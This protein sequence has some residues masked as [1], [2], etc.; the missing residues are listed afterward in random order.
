MITI[1]KPQISEAEKRAV[2]RVMDSGMIAYGAKV[3]EF[4]QSFADYCG[5]NHGVATTS[6]TTA[7]EVAL[8]ALGIAAGDKV[9]TTAWSFIASTNSILYTGAIPVFVDIDRVSFNIDPEGLESALKAHP[10][11]KAVQIVHLFGQPCNMDRIMPIIRKYGVWLIEDCAQAHGAEWNGQKV[12]SFGD[13]AAFSFY[14]TKNMTTGEGGIVLTKDPET[15]HRARLLTNHGMEQRYT[16]DILGYN[17]RMTNIS[18]AIGLEQLQ[19]LD[20]FNEARRKNADYYSQ[21]ISQP[22]VKTPHVPEDAHHV[23]HQYTLE[24][25]D[26]YRDALIKHFEKNE[27]GYGVF[28]PY[29]IP[30]QP[31]YQGMGFDQEWPMTDMIKQRALSIP[32][33]PGLSVSDIKI[34]AQTINAFE[35]GL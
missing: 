17:Y 27:I 21:H 13:A 12:G 31:A 19:R 23:Y 24:V 4:E 35:G 25:A 32:V 16:H 5:A 33:H 3:T 15:A 6:G 20:G 18:A 14:P 34:V 11:A 8:R 30:E 22:L 1:A 28:Y 9:V 10:D 29:S 26:G 2:L 7:L